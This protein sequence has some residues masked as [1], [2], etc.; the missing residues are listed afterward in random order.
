MSCCRSS[1]G[2]SVLNMTSMGVEDIGPRGAEAP[3]E[4]TKGGPSTY[5]LHV[6]AGTRQRQHI[7]FK[8]LLDSWFDFLQK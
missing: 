4:M 8:L 2:V 7:D 6:T 3:P 5:G 1:D